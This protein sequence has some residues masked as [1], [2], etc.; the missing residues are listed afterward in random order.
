MTNQFLSYKSLPPYCNSIISTSFFQTKD[1]L[2]LSDGSYQFFV[3][4]VF[5]NHLSPQGERGPVGGQGLQGP[6][7]PGGPGGPRGDRG[8]PGDGGEQVNQITQPKTFRLES[9]LIAPAGP[10]PEWDQER[11]DSEGRG[12]LQPYRIDVEL[13]INSGRFSVSNESCLN[14][15][16][17]VAIAR[18]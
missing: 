3:L 10:I 4:S 12:T 7:G 17:R 14:Y 5:P 13:V 9:W 15:L 11:F 18:L 8:L 6:G 2:P 1:S 16:N